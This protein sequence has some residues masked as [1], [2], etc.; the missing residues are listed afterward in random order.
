MILNYFIPLHPYLTCFYEIPLATHRFSHHSVS[1][2]HPFRAQQGSTRGMVRSADFCVRAC[3]ANDCSIHRRR[4]RTDVERP[5][6]ELYRHRILST[7]HSRTAVAP[8]LRTDVHEPSAARS[9]C[10]YPFRCRAPRLGIK[11]PEQVLSAQLVILIQSASIQPR[12]V[13]GSGSAETKPNL[14]PIHLPSFIWNS[15]P[16]G[17]NFFPFRL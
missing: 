11:T 5:T 16:Q 2:C 3:C 1:N 9:L 7:G 14:A 12:S 17:V 6:G 13:L 8:L 10:L 4:Y 15:S